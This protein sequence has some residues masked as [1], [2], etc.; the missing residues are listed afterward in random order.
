MSAFVCSPYHFGSVAISLNSL[1]NREY[2]Y[3]LKDVTHNADGWPQAI[4]W[5]FEKVYAFISR[6][7][8]IQIETVAAK[9]NDDPNE[10]EQW[11]PVYKDFSIQ[12][13]GH[14]LNTVALYKAL[15]CIEYQIEPEH[16]PDKAEEWEE[17]LTRLRRLM[18]ELTD[19]IISNLPEYKA[20]PWGVDGLAFLS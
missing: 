8:A 10:Y 3:S 1:H 7:S 17:D 6:L 9:Y 11:K 20:A 18:I 15:A 5:D 12:I 19:K 4:K 16:C 14:E 13:D 2:L